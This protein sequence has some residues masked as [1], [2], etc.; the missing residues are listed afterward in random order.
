MGTPQRIAAFT[1]GAAGGNPAGVMICSEL[2]DPALMQA[3]ARDLGYS[4]TVFAAP[5]ETGWRVRYFSPTMEVPFC[6]HATIALGAALAWE[7]GD[8]TFPLLLNDGAISVHGR[9]DGDTVAATLV[10]PPASSRA[11]PADLIVQALALFGYAPDEMDRRLPPALIR[12]GGETGAQF[13]L[14]ALETRE[15]LR[16]MRYTQDDGA[17][18]MRAAGLTT[19]ALVHAR[20]PRDFDARNAF[21]IGGVYEDPATG[22]AAAALGGYLRDL[23]WPHGGAIDILQGVDMG[24]PCRLTVEIPAD[25]TVPVRVSGQARYITA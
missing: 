22:A 14:L 5:E 23:G 24:Q 7:W 18:L 12:L 6:G 8:A 3:I 21:A 25:P 1:D 19:I 20:S 15:A 17:A 16:R 9:R 4:E 13:L 11:A 10:A 2:P